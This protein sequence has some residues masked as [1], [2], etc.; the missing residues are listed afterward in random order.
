MTVSVVIP[1]YRAAAVIGR[2]LKSVAAQ[3]VQP[4]LVIVVD[5]GSDDG[6]AEAARALSN[7]FEDGVLMVIEQSNRGPGAARNRGLSAAAST[8]I[9]FLD[10]DDEWLPEHLE[11]SLGEMAKGNFV[12]TAHDFL[13]IRGERREHVACARRF[14]G[15]PDP[16][17]GLYRK[18]FI[19][20]STV[21]ARR[22]AIVAAGGFDEALAAAQDFDLWLTMTAAPGAQ[23]S[24]FDD[25]LTLYYPSPGGITGKT[26]QRLRCT[27]RVAGRHAASLKGR[28]GGVLGNLWNR[29]LAVHYEAARAFLAKG[30]FIGLFGVLAVLP[31]NLI[32]QSA[33]VLFRRRHP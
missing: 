15:M 19:G 5:D 9:A 4:V 29:V 7:I 24:V 12:L 10:A 17:V 28:P 2:A 3:T 21:L 6:T 13:A 8:Y 22:D 1:A 14:R 16:F 30:D 31:V 18:G 26:R 32:S 27:L 20:A 33:G 23:F 11:R 25:P